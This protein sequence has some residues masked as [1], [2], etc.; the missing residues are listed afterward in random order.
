MPSHLRLKTPL[1]LLV[2]VVS[3]TAGL[4]Y[5][6]L[7]ARMFGQV[8]GSSVEAVATILACFMAGF[9]LGGLV[10]G[11]LA[12]RLAKPL[13]AYVWMEL[14]IALLG[15]ALTFVIPN[16]GAVT[17][18]LAE[19][20]GSA[21]G[22]L[23][24]G[25]VAV[26]ALITIPPTMLMGGTLP[27][28]TRYLTRGGAGPGR[29][30]AL[31]YAANTC[32]AVVGCL[33]PDFFLVQ[34][35]GM[36]SSAFVACGLNC[37]A[38]GLALWIHTK[39][40]PV[41]ATGEGMLSTP[42]ATVRKSVELPR[43]S[44]RIVL[45]AIALSGLAAMG[46]EVLWVR[47]NTYYNGSQVY[48]FSAMLAVYLTGLALGG[49]I[50]ARWVD[51]VPNRLAL[52]GH[53]ELWIGV[54][55]LG[56]MPLVIWAH[57]HVMGWFAPRVFALWGV[58]A[59]G[60]FFTS[61]L[62]SLT[63]TSI[64]VLGPTILLG[65]TIPVAAR[66]LCDTGVSAPRAIG[67]VYFWNTLL[68][69]P[70]ALLVGFFLIRWPGSQATLTLL[71]TGNVLLGV[72]L[73]GLAHRR[74]RTRLVFPGLVMGGFL[75]ALLVLPGDYLV[76]STYRAS[77]DKIADYREGTHQTMVLVQ[78]EF[79][80]TPI[81]ERLV[82]GNFSMTARS[83]VSARY[84][85]LMAHLPALLAER[86]RSACLICFGLGST[87]EG[88]VAEPELEEIDV[89]DISPEVF[90]IYRGIFPDGGAL[91]D[92]RVTTHADDG[93]NH[94]LACGRTYD[95][96]TLE[97]P[98]P[99]NAGV[100]N[101]YSREFYDLARSRLSPGGALCQWIPFGEA[102]PLEM[103]SMLRAFVEVFPDATLWHGVARQ[104]V[105]VGTLGPRSLDP[106]EI[107]AHMAA[108]G[109]R[110]DLHS[111]G[112]ESVHDLLATLILGPADLAAYTEGASP[113]TD[114]HPIISHSLVTWSGIDVDLDLFRHV[115]DMNQVLALPAEWTGSERD[116]FVSQQAREQ[117]YWRSMV[118]SMTL[119]PGLGVVDRIAERDTSLGAFLAIKPAHP[120]V[121][122]YARLLPRMTE[123]AEVA[124]E[125]DPG[126]AEALVHLG[127]VSLYRNA[128][129]RAVELLER[130]LAAGPAEPA[131]VHYVLGRSYALLDR[132]SE[133]RE[134]YSRALDAYDGLNFRS[135]VQKL[136]RGLED[137]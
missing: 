130:A 37:L 40:V 43:G 18:G 115:P 123:A 86:P 50:I 58:D 92:P 120:L 106:V 4:V 79:L 45:T 81:E 83:F 44:A 57:P 72:V 61:T 30:I 27:V 5:E 52:L 132:L 20:L 78:K 91:A 70:G 24:I 11:R 49:V 128:P 98:P 107:E 54:I 111:I 87:L 9:A 17:E 64:L 69:I 75:V 48:N 15:G 76:Q 14:L 46:Y 116:A 118:N 84:M 110:E 33:L 59:Q 109:T 55:A 36:R 117:Q 124:L 133:A 97:P 13:V 125:S 31:L 26:V 122:T 60:A 35:L 66:I 101:L 77:H 137:L 129:A 99:R 63:L 42:V 131:G 68:G 126:N 1:L 105:L 89:V 56:S 88:L 6:V 102:T 12:S 127:L 8:F 23:V 51:R 90:E 29:L 53:L 73:L 41:I 95:I 74:R 62:A 100:A 10:F 28:M 47:L 3:G 19:L 39:S 103:R 108:P 113:V 136:L 121:M 134:S 22:P 65:A 135:R 71:A 96:I 2:F 85:K 16:L 38:A 94:L 34:A 21:R 67:R 80:G 82:T 112:I 93:R 114:D 119:P 7:W 25:R 104:T 32:G